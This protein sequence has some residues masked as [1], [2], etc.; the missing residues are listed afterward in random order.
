MQKAYKQLKIKTLNM[1]D[2]AIV[3]LILGTLALIIWS[4]KKDSKA[5]HK[6]DHKNGIIIDIDGNKFIK[7]NHPGCKILED[8]DFPDND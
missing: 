3:L 5:S 6:C 8:P 2:I 7:C 4:N 1:E